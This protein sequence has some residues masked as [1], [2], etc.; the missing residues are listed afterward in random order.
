MAGDK[1][2]CIEAGCDDYL[3]KPFSKKGLL[4]KIRKYLLPEEQASIE[5]AMLN[6]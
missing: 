5:T 4:G 3:A 1:K 2:K 6:D